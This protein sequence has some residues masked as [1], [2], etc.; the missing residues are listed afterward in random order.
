[1]S[2]TV[3]NDSKRQNKSQGKTHDPQYGG[4]VMCVDEQRGTG[5]R[6]GSDPNKGHN[7]QTASFGHKLPVPHSEYNGDEPV[8]ANRTQSRC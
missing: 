3:D 8:D 6:Q 5:E 1:V 7:A 2:V 4:I